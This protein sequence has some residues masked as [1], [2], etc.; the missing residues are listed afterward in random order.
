MRYKTIRTTTGRRFR[1]PMS[2]DEIVERQMYWLVVT[3]IP[4]ISSA[5]MFLIWVKG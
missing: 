1:V 3:M 5:L 4:F 2:E